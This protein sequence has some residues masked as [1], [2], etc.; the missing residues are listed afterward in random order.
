MRK[1]PPVNTPQINNTHVCVQGI[2]GIRRQLE[3]DQYLEMLNTM[4]LFFSFSIITKFAVSKKKK[5]KVLFKNFKLWSFLRFEV[6]LD[7]DTFKIHIP[8]LFGLDKTAK[9]WNFTIFTIFTIFFY[10]TIYF[11]YFRCS[12]IPV[13]QISSIH[14]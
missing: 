7:F 13:V 9:E 3:L 8:S 6:L 10:K 12:C 11:V 14:Y 4:L 2:V 1:T 5:S